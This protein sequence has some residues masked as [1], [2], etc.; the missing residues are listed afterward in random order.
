MLVKAEPFNLVMDGCSPG[1]NEA[2]V[3]EH[4]V[5]RDAPFAGVPNA[6]DRAG[7]H[8][9]PSRDGKTG[10]SAS[11]P[12]LSLMRIS[13]SEAQRTRAGESFPAIHGGTG[14]SGEAGARAAHAQD[15]GGAAARPVPDGQGGRFPSQSPSG[16]PWQR[17]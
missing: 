3:T 15:P 16:I 11:T 12:P 10:L 6:V 9:A 8:G 7:E 17:G 5:Q 1:H 2:M 14:W 13:R 4:P